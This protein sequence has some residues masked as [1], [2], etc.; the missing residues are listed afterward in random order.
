M[1]LP[2]DGDDE[3]GDY[4]QK[5]GLVRDVKT[6]SSYCPLCRL[7]LLSLG[8]EVPDEKNG[9]PLEVSFSWTTTGLRRPHSRKDRDRISTIREIVPSVELQGGGFVDYP[10][11]ILFPR[12]GILAND[13]PTPHKSLC[14]RFIKDQIDFTMVQNWISICKTRHIKCAG[15]HPDLGQGTITDL[16]AEIPSLRMIDVIDS[17][18]IPAPHNCNYVALSYVWGKVDPLTIL[19]SLKSNTAELEIPGALAQSIH[20]SKIPLT[21][22]DAMIVVKE[23]GMRYLWVDSLC[24]VQDDFGPGGSKMQAIAKMGLVYGAAALTIMAVMGDATTGLSGVHPGAKRS[25]PIEEIKPGLRL[26]FMQM[27]QSSLA[28]SVYET[29]GWTCVGSISSMNNNTDTKT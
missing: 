17:C 2:G 14:S 23:I 15:S 16:V 25:Q 22:R 29:R 1:V 12:I 24:I 4:L 6:N 8:P 28:E 7:V 19:R 9:V 11:P 18:V 21:I 26:A 5:F 3:A 20:Y 27:Y 13:A 10:T